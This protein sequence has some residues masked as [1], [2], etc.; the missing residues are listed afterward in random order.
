MNV[1]RTCRTYYKLAEQALRRM[2]TN[3]QLLYSSL[4]VYSF[5]LLPL[6][7]ENIIDRYF[8]YLSGTCSGLAQYN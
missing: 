2:N 6:Y 7:T 8:V 3:T 5:I 4:L 1:R